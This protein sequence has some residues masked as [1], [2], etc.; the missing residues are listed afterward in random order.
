M[1][2]HVLLNWGWGMEDATGKKNG[3]GKVEMDDRIRL[4]SSSMEKVA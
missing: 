3:K 2:W 4:L 1:Y